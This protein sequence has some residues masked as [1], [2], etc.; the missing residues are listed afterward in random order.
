MAGVS[1]NVKIAN[2]YPGLDTLPDLLTKI[3][4]LLIETKTD[5]NAVL[6]KLDADAGVTDTDYT[7]LHTLSSTSPGDPDAAT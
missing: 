2:N 3:Y 5:F 1:L 4:D 6:A 7:S